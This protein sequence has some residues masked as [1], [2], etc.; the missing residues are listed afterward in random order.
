MLD[1]TLLDGAEEKDLSLVRRKASSFTLNHCSFHSLTILV[2][3][4][5]KLFPME[6]LLPLYLSST[7]PLPA[8]I[9]PAATQQQV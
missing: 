8:R 9:K 3:L 2:Y 7:S 5:T 4:R 6:I 1:I